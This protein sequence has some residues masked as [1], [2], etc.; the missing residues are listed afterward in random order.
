MAKSGKSNKQK[1][2]E[3]KSIFSKFFKNNSPETVFMNVSIKL[4]KMMGDY[5]L[6][7]KSLNHEEKNVNQF[8]RR[9]QM[10]FI[11]KRGKNFNEKSM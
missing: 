6:I 5:S 1:L 4:S 10:N 8:L 7:S 3:F 9:V 2:E 11:D